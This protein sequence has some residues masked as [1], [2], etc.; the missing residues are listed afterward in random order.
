MKF[1]LRLAGMTPM[2]R[3]ARSRLAWVAPAVHRR[4][5]T[6][7][8]CVV[9]H[10]AMRSCRRRRGGAASSGVDDGL[11]FAGV[12]RHELK[13]RRVVLEEGPAYSAH[14]SQDT[15]VIVRADF[16]VTLRGIGRLEH[17]PAAASRHRLDRRLVAETRGYNVAV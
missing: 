5:P 12:I 6:A 2:G 13:L 7:E 14:D 9:A 11:G 16:D 15:E 17:G 4:R 10:P 3:P 1:R 8:N